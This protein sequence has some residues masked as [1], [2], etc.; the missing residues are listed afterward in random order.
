LKTVI[1]NIGVGVRSEALILEKH[2]LFGIVLLVELE[3]LGPSIGDV[4]NQECP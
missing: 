4:K 2:T 3:H 1:H